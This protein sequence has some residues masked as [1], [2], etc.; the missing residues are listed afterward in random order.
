M[1]NQNNIIPM[2]RWPK[3]LPLYVAEYEASAST[4]LYTLEEIAEH[5]KL[6][7]EVMERFM[8]QESF[9]AEVRASMMELKDTNSIVRQ[10]AKAQLETYIDNLVPQWMVD[11][12]FPAA[13][14]NK[15]LKFLHELAEGGDV[16]ALKAKEKAGQ[17]GNGSTTLNLYLTTGSGETKPISGITID[18]EAIE[19]KEEDKDVNE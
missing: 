2:E 15:T 8:Q 5:F 13:E 10:K 9:Q 7:M 6:S 11:P 19:E 14:K 12:E 3:M 1:S 17:L 16:A 4:P 18:Q